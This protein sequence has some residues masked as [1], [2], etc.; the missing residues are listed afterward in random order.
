M[1]GVVPRAA[2]GLPVQAFGVLMRRGQVTGSVLVMNGESLHRAVFDSRR[3]AIPARVIE[4]TLPCL[5]SLGMLAAA[6]TYR[7]KPD[8][9]MQPHIALAA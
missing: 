9:R 8:E 7:G 1:R 2:G 4:D 5:G 6:S 3:C